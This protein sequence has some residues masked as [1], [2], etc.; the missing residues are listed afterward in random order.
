MYFYILNSFIIILSSN[1][2]HLKI[3]YNS[4]VLLRKTV[5]TSVDDSPAKNLQLLV[6]FS[7]DCK[8]S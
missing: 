4:W 7:I 6:I 3:I 8:H 5:N 1:D 2:D